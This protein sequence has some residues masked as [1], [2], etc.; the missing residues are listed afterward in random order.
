MVREQGCDTWV[1]ASFE[2]LS[3]EQRVRGC[4]WPCLDVSILL[5]Q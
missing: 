1:P 5:G 2:G 3:H 4:T